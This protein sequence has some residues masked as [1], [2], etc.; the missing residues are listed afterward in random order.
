M[1]TSILAVCFI[2]IAG[3]IWPNHSI[4]LD[5]ND[6]ITLSRNQAAADLSALDRAYQRAHAGF[7]RHNDR[8]AIAQTLEAIQQRLPETISELEL[9][10]EVALY[11]SSVRD[12][13]SGVRPSE[14]LHRRMQ[15]EQVFVPIQ[16]LFYGDKIFVDHTYGVDDALRGS[17]IL[18]INNIPASDILRELAARSPADGTSFGPR[19]RRFQR[20]F[21]IHYFLFVDE[22]DE[23]VIEFAEPVSDRPNRLVL[24]GVSYQ[25]ILDNSEDLYATDAA[26]TLTVFEDDDLAVLR[27]TNFLSPDTDE[28]FRALFGRL[29]TLDI[30]DLVIDLRGNPGGYE[31]HHVELLRYLSSHPFRFYTGWTHSSPTFDDLPG[32]EI[33]A[34][35]YFYE[36]AHPIPPEEQQRLIEDLSLAERLDLS[37]STFASSGTHEPY[38]ELV[39]GGEVYWLIDGGSSSS[40]AEVPGMAHYL[41]LGTIIGEEPNVA[42]S[43]TTAGIIPLLLLPNSGIRA[44]LPLIAYHTAIHDQIRPHQA[45]APHFAVVQTPHDLLLGI[46]TAMDF[47]RNL[48][49]VRRGRWDRVECRQPQICAR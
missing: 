23:F 33:E 41:G 15:D 42:Y 13:H 45:P 27:I 34:N 46:D 16:P 48:I 44:R 14:R 43:G 9:L 6:Q 25:H 31:K 4:A 7:D 8:A 28:Q 39:F 22:S 26:I 21:P 3:A 20:Q 32:V 49:F 24:D 10:R 47:A 37:I 5:E 36:A 18:S 17:E 40:G 29:T 2:I 38:S 1:R 30:D 11:T 12:G 19:H 35:S